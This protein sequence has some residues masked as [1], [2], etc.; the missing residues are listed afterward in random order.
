MTRHVVFLRH[1]QSE[2]NAERGLGDERLCGQ[3]ETP[4]TAI[5]RQQ[6]IDAGRRLALR[7]DLRIAQAISST[8]SRA[9]ETLDLILAQLPADVV[10]LAAAADFNERSLGCWEGLRESEVFARWPE[11]R[12]GNLLERSRGDYV[13]KAPGGENLRE[14]A[15]RAWNELERVRRRGTAGLLIVSHAMTIR[16]LV[17]RALGLRPADW[18]HLPVK[19]SQPIVLRGAA[20]DE[21]WDGR[22]ERIE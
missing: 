1:G 13:L 14:V 2:M 9:V 4:L 18:N 12:E 6:A 16:C 11:A 15:E 20:G 22:M 10:R 7:P 8:L 17:G 19:N 21:A 5:G 3:F